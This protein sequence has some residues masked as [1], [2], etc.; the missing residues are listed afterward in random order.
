[1]S[2]SGI[3]NDST[4]SSCSSP[5]WKYVDS[6][7]LKYAEQIKQEKQL[8]NEVRYSLTELQVSTGIS[9]ARGF[10]PT[11]RLINSSN[12]ISLMDLDWYD[13]ITNIHIVPDNDK[14]KTFIETVVEFENFKISKEAFICLTT[15][16]KEVENDAWPD[17]WKRL[18]PSKLPYS[19]IN[20]LVYDFNDGVY[21]STVYYYKVKLITKGDRKAYDSNWKLMRLGNTVDDM[22]SFSSGTREYVPLISSLLLFTA[23]D[24]G[25]P[26]S[27]QDICESVMRPFSDFL[28]C[29]EVLGASPITQGPPVENVRDSIARSPPL[30]CEY[31]PEE[32]V[33][34]VQS[35]GSSQTPGPAKWRQTSTLKESI[36]L[37][38]ARSNSTNSALGGKRGREETNQQEELTEFRKILA[39]LTAGSE[40]LIKYIKNKCEHKSGNQT[41]GAE[42]QKEIR[43][44]KEIVDQGADFEGL[45]K[46]IDKNWPE[47]I[48]KITKEEE[49]RTLNARLKGHLAVIIDPNTETQDK[50]MENVMF[51]FPDI[52]TLIQEGLAEGQVEYIRNNM[53]TISS[54]GLRGER[55]NTLFVLPYKADENGINDIPAMYDLLIKL[56]AEM[57]IENSKAVKIL[58]IGNHKKDYIRKCAEVIFRKTEYEIT[59]LT[60][61]KTDR[62]K[63]ESKPRTTRTKGPQTDKIII[64]SEGKTYAELL[65]S[66]KTNVDI[67]E[68]GVTI[69]S[70]KKT[71]KDTIIAKTED[72]EVF[73]KS[74][75][76]T[77][78]ITD[79]DAD[80]NEEELKKEIV[81]SGAGV[82]EEQLSVISLRPNGSGNQTATVKMRKDITAELVKRG[83]IKIGWVLCRLRRRVNIIRCYKCLDFGHRTSECTGPDKSDL[84]INCGKRGHKA[85]DCELKVSYCI[86]CKEEGHRADTTKYPY[87]RKLIKDQGNSSRK[88]RK[89]YIDVTGATANI[90]RKV[91]RWKVLSGEALTFHHHIIFEIDHQKNVGK[92]QQNIQT[93]F[94]N[95]KF[96]ET[97]RRELT[98]R[99]VENVEDLI[100]VIGTATRE[101][102]I[103]IRD[104]ERKRPYWWNMEIENQRE[105]C[106]R[107]R[108]Q[109]TRANARNTSRNEEITAL[110][111][112]YKESCKELKKLISR[113]KRGHWKSLC[114]ELE[115]AVW[116][117]GYKIV[118][119]HLGSQSL[120]FNLSLDRKTEIKAQVKMAALTWLLPNVGGPSG[121]KRAILC[122]V[123]QSVV[124]YGAPVWYQAINVLK[125]KKMLLGIQRKAL[126]R[127]ASG[128]RTISTSAIQ[129]VTGTPPLS[130]LIEERYRLYHIENAQLP[131][132]AHSRSAR[133]DEVSHKL[134]PIAVCRKHNWIARHL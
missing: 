31:T 128:Y 127:I 107:L 87:F 54:K 14:E 126:L 134:E 117:S 46:I 74:N 77:L 52:S 88:A 99:E 58:A 48:F 86:T 60:A 6:I 59:I 109:T 29:E 106:L 119:K 22:K 18:T 90:S 83:K 81:K 125:Y 33:T 53:E 89:S 50:R 3:E 112:Q 49:S 76:A 129:V 123:I 69:K 23:F 94:D 10:E 12:V 70:L 72:T 75:D 115:N 101:S 36:D 24:L 27:K 8:I 124:L 85:K 100:T 122:G 82:S 116:G 114:S 26:P 68:V 17:M 67:A 2:D 13:F 42:K 110:Q 62:L 121:P 28:R 45:S 105:K 47:E 133:A 19:H 1:M 111:T 21:K 44:I 15:A 98:A 84:C 71:E 92:M 25:T 130:L 55:S 96:K 37:T 11:V 132:S 56:K 16:E 120:P 93:L 102:T 91:K 57:P 131:A 39:K 66:V 41:R 32:T 43:E 61:N 40:E 104:G 113:S 65:R 5:Y 79:I 20:V 35:Q 34:N 63:S 95:N 30:K 97:I 118:M 73:V 78:H 103:T 4:T 9:A 64:K 51:S 80:I 108:R 38:R 7:L